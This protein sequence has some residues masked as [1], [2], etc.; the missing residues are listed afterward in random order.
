MKRALISVS[1]KRDLVEFARKLKELD[2]DI[3]AT[4]G[5]AK[6]LKENGV[7]VKRLS[8]LTGLEESKIIKTLHPEVFRRIYS[9]FFDLIVVNLY[10]P[11]EEI[12]IGGVT[13][14]R[15]GAKNYKNVLTVCD[16]ND[17]KYVVELLKKGI[18]DEIRLRFAIKAIEYVL[19]Y[20]KKVLEI[21]RS[22]CS[23]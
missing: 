1:D 20:D 8:E 18:D 13:L 23:K 7:E 21:Y 17:Y 15:A 14:L 22:Q 2:Y 16:V 3:Y 19:E 9:G 11:K 5:T 10:D 4:D 6:F 12:D